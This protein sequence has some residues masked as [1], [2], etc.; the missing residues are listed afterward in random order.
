MKNTQHTPVPLTVI[1]GGIDRLRTK[2][3]ARA[4][5]LYELT[6]G[7]VTE[8]M[9]VRARQGT[10]RRMSLPEGTVGLVAFDGCLHVFA[11]EV[12]EIPQSIFEVTAAAVNGHVLANNTSIGEISP[13]DDVVG[14]LTFV[15]AIYQTATNQLTLEFDQ[16]ITGTIDTIRVEH[17][18]G[19]QDLQVDGATEDP[20]P[21]YGAYAL[22][23]LLDAAWTDAGVY[24][25]SFNPET[26]I[27]FEVDVLMHPS[28]PD[29]VLERIHYAAPFLGALYVVAEFESGE[30]FHYWLQDA[31]PWA[32]DTEYSLHELV[33]PTT[34]NGLYFRATRFGQ[35]YQ[36]WAPGVARTAGNGSSIDPSIIEPTVYNEYYYTA[37]QTG[38]DNPRSGSVEPT[39][40]VN[41]GETIVENTD[42]FESTTPDAVAPPAP[43]AN[44]QPQSGTTERYE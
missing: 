31:D 39:W 37:I 3:G 35:G 1:K 25:V 20:T 16:D 33:T 7:Y 44:N 40:P 19:T 24:T 6:N 36:A 4:D 22:V 23:F 27:C 30:I 32:A 9:T 12:L 29:A 11:S 42:G 2:A 18:G 8:R 43:P 26:A 34:P 10:W 17:D 14:G 5:S 38:G 41:T 15:A 13:G 28:D 21:L